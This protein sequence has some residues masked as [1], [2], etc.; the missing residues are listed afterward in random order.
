M[1]VIRL[2]STVIFALLLSPLLVHAAPVTFGFSGTVFQ[3]TFDPDDPFA[4][5]VGFGSIFSGHYTFDST[6]PD[7]ASDSQTGSYASAGAPFGMTVDFGGGT[8]FTAADL[9]NVGVANDFAGPVDQ[10]TVL[11]TTNAGDLTLELF[12]EDA[13]ATVFGSD[14][15]PVTPPSLAAFWWSQFSLIGDVSGNHVEIQ[16]AVD[17]LSCQSGCG[18]SPVPEPGAIVLLG[19]AVAALAVWRQRPGAS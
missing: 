3:A 8:S 17:S 12:F 6:A 5:A 7:G 16:G 10:Y 11:A 4:G 15:L 14:A 2:A 13:T 18:P 1:R 19:T 9:L